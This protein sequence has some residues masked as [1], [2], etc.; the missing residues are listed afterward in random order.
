MIQDDEFLSG[1]VKLLDL[2]KEFEPMEYWTSQLPSPKDKIVAQVC[3]L[4][5]EATPIQRDVFLSG[6]SERIS[7]VLGFFAERMAMLS[8][9][10]NSEAVLQK[11][12]VA[13]IIQLDWLW[14]DP[15]DG[16]IADLDLISVS[17]TRIQ[18]DPERLFGIGTQIAVRQFTKDYV[19]ARQHIPISEHDLREG[20]IWEVVEGPAGLIY[21]RRGKPIPEGHRTQS[22]DCQRCAFR[23][24]PDSGR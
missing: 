22:A 10:Q 15:R 1:A 23:V 7:A 13:L 3:D 19:Y 9:R 16:A 2:L 5:I 17:A 24:P 8:V 20:M 14:T 18:Y 12:L 4:Y 11:G 6:L 21:H